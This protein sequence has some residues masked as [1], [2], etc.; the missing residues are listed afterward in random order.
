MDLLFYTCGCKCKQFVQTWP[1]GIVNSNPCTVR[2]SR[3][4]VSSVFDVLRRR[5]LKDDNLCCHQVA[6]VEEIEGRRGGPEAVCYVDRY[7]SHV[8]VSD[9][10]EDAAEKIPRSLSSVSP[11]I[12]RGRRC[13]R[14]LNSRAS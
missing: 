1:S 3:L 5:A 13:R 10:G 12:D 14:R 11:F 7:Q 6:G 8:Y 4:A 9:E 2:C